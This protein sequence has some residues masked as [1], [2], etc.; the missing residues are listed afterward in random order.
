MVFH[1]FAHMHHHAHHA[2]CAAHAV[3]AASVVTAAQV[4]TSLFA[5]VAVG[6]MLYALCRRLQSLVE[7]GIL[8]QEQAEAFKSKASSADEKTKKEMLSDANNLCEKYGIYI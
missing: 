3:H 7:A 6:T 1:L 4:A 8:S 2:A 5:G